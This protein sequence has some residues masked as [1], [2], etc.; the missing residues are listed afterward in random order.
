MNSGIFQTLSE[1]FKRQFHWIDHTRMSFSNWA[2][3]EPNGHNS[4]TIVEDV[5]EMYPYTYGYIFGFLSF[6]D[7]HIC[8]VT[9]SLASGTISI[10]P[11]NKLLF[12]HIQYLHRK[13]SPVLLTVLMVGL[14]S[15]L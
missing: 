8:S 4:E 14:G 7:Y 10:Q 1:S 15:I 12:A 2:P 5:A 9:M 3:G 13:P 6:I 11:V